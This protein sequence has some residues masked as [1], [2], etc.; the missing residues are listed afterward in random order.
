MCKGCPQN[1]NINN[2]LSYI[3]TKILLNIIVEG[4]NDFME[5]KK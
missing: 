5:G 2:S 4:K 1:F 3:E